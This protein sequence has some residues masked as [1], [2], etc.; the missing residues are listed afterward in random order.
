MDRKPLTEHGDGHY[1]SGGNLRE[2]L[3]DL[4]L[5]MSAVLG[6][7]SLII[8]LFKL[9]SQDRLWFILVHA[10]PYSG[11]LILIAVRRHFSSGSRAIA[12]LFG[13]FLLGGGVLLRYGL[14]GGGVWV[15]LTVCT[16]V[17]VLFG[18]KAGLGTLAASLVML[19]VAGVAF[20]CGWIVLTPQTAVLDGGSLLSWVHAACLFTMLA[21][22]LTVVPGVLLREEERVNRDLQVQVSRRDAAEM[23]LRTAHEELEQRVAARTH[24]LQT[25]NE[26]LAAEVV[27]RGLLENELARSERLA[28]TGHLAASVAHEVNSPLQGMISLL[29][30]I[31]KKTGSDPALDEKVALVGRACDSIRQ[32]VRRLMDLNRPETGRRGTLELNEVIR[33][34]ALLTQGLLQRK[35]ITIRLE[36]ASDLPSIEAS[37]AEVA[38]CLMNLVMN[39]MEAIEEQA[40]GGNRQWICIATT[41]RADKV[42]ATV[43]DS[44]PGIPEQDLPHLFLPFY[45]RRKK[46]GMGVGLSICHHIVEGHAGTLEAENVKTG[47]ALFRMAFPVAQKG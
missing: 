3:L 45:T 28:A 15:L 35:G 13:F 29:S 16:L 5:A 8:I 25:A 27:E 19:M 34:T 21:G 46:M 42:V 22:V 18:F 10:I 2:H 7:P 37:R 26:R 23:Q 11:V 39:A 12:F 1:R 9:V 36:L 31:R 24:E 30:V 20:L 33:D 43:T 4:M 44:G 40:C 14:T 41:C 17:T 38:Q 47:G 6:L 32:T